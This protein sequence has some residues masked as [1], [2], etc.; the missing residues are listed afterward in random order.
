MKE[1]T[2]RKR[3][4]EETKRLEM[5]ARAASTLQDVDAALQDFEATQNKLL[6]VVKSDDTVIIGDVRL[7]GSVVSEI[8]HAERERAKDETISGKFTVLANDTTTNPGGF[9]LK[10]SRLNDSLIL[11]A[12]VPIDLAASQKDIIRDAEWS[13]GTK[14]IE[15]TIQ[16]E[17][18]RGSI[19]NAQV[20]SVG[21]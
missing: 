15:M 2:D 20:I 4:E 5:M 3:V 1:D 21:N 10:V 14:V 8:V 18:L 7:P 19:T 11:Y 6:K 13:R 12:N 9:R 16:A 17:V